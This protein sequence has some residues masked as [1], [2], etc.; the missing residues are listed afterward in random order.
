MNQQ[1][2]ISSIV[3]SRDF[4]SSLSA[5][6]TRTLKLIP[7]AKI[8]TEETISCKNQSETSTTSGP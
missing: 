7:N 1:L 3:S 8:T 5:K 4:S 6:T 2:K